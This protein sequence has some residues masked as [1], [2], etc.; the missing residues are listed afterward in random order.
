MACYFSEGRGDSSSICIHSGTDAPAV[1]A[2]ISLCCS[3]LPRV[4]MC[5]SVLQGV[6]VCCSVLPCVAVCGSVLPCVAV[7]CSHSLSWSL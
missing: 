7:C 2:S 3:V 4:A 6:A 1:I 5:C